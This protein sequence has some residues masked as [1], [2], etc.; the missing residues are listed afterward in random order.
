MSIVKPFLATIVACALSAGSAAFAQAP[1]QAP[2]APAAKPAQAPPPGSFAGTW[3]SDWGKLEIEVNGRKVTGKY[4]RRLGGI[5]GE[6]TEDGRS[7]MGIW[8]QA[9][10]YVLGRDGGPFLFTLTPNGNSFDGYIWMSGEKGGAPMDFIAV[11]ADTKSP[12]VFKEG[13]YGRPRPPG[14]E[15]SWAKPVSDGF[16]GPWE[17]DWGTLNIVV[18]GHDV[19]GTFTQGQ[20]RIE[21]TISNDGK[22]LRGRWRKGPTYKVGADGGAFVFSMLPSEKAFEGIYYHLDEEKGIGTRMRATRPKAPGA[23]A[24]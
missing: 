18:S 5:E 14:A 12:L 3:D 9:P 8:C 20:G 16:S 11:R 17:S 21:G 10:S 23:P 19:R 7:A 15:E 2:I 24:R 4:A 6:I 1:K 22:T 13:P